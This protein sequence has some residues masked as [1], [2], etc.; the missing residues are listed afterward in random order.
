MQSQ[1]LSALRT[2]SGRQREASDASAK[3]EMNPISF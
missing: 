3:Q 2:E 1:E